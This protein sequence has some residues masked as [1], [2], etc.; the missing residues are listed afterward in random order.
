M[1][2]AKREAEK[3]LVEERQMGIRQRAC[4]GKT[5]RKQTKSLLRKD[6]REA[7]KELLSKSTWEADKIKYI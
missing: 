4:S 7:D 1:R 6:R 5:L 3:E 2:K